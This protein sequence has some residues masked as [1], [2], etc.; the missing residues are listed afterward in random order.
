MPTAT[1]TTCI[2]N[3]STPASLGLTGLGLTASVTITAPENFEISTNSDDTYSSSLTL[4]NSN[5]VSQTLYIRLNSTAADGIYSGTITA[6]STGVT[7]AIATISRT[8]LSKPSLSTSAIS[9]CSDATYLITKTSAIPAVGNGWTVSGAI[10]V[11]DGCVTAGATPGNYTVSYT[12]GCAQ[13]ASSTVLV[14][15]TSNLS[16]IT[17]GQASYK[18]DGTPKGPSSA[19]Y[20]MGYNGFTY[21]SPEKP[22]NTGFYKANN[23]FGSEGGCP[24]TFYIFRCT[25]CPD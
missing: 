18:F 22:T 3:S 25:T 16:V 6:T 9:L 4:T 10:T 19:S 1:L 7:D 24:F 17:D 11:N 13:T 5:T 21:S 23:Q 15:P 8:V 12:D 20:F 2:G 14:S